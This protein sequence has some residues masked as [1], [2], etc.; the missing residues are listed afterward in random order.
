MYKFHKQ[1]TNLQIK[2]FIAGSYH[3]PDGAYIALKELAEER[4]AALNAA[5]VSAIRTEG[6]LAQAAAMKQSKFIWEQ[7][8]GEAIELEYALARETTAVL[9]QAA[10]AELQYINKC[11]DELLPM[12]KYAHL[13][14]AEVA[15]LVQTEEWRLELINRA[16]NSLLTIGTIPTDQFATMRLHP[17]FN[18]WILPTIMKMRAAIESK[19]TAKVLQ[20]AQSTK[21][22]PA[23]NT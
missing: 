22:L 19:D 12:R 16:C 15:E 1:N 17:D 18:D 21:A 23:R 13:P 9:L 5:K 11:I 2:H 8:E 3:T 10:E 20:I 6:K 7:K 4:V 14:D